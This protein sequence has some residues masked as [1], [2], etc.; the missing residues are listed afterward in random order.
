MRA[1]IIAVVIVGTVLYAGVQ[2]AG[3]LVARSDLEQKAHELAARVSE[4]TIGQ[5][6]QD[7]AREAAGRGIELSPA[8][9][10]IEY[11][12]TTDRTVAQGFVGRI[13]DFTNKRVTIRAAYDTRVLGIVWRQRI[14]AT[15]IIQVQARPRSH[16][17]LEQMMDAAPPF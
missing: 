15:R 8:D 16:S 9:I 5:V 7:L 13:G 14:E 11:A 2:V 12:D 3:V 6:K 4:Q 1:L 17:E 10:E